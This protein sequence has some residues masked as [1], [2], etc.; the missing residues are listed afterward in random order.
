LA[1]FSIQP[2][3]EL[4]YPARCAGCGREGDWLC[5]GCLRL[6]APSGP[7]CCP[8]CG[9][10]LRS[11]ECAICRDRLRSLESVGAAYEYIGPARD[12]VRRFKYEGM[13]AAAG[14]MAERILART[15]LRGDVLT[16]VPMHPRRQRERGYNQ[17][18]A[19]ARA[20]GRA[21]GL[22]VACSL[23]R[24]RHTDAQARLG[25]HERWTNVRGAFAAA[26]AAPAGARVVLVDD[27]CTTCATLEECAATLKD[28]GAAHVSAVVFAR[29]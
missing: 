24:T 26:A 18:E 29:A 15:E 11:P 8:R 3:W 21:T 12:L 5:A 23:R 19:L 6:C 22:P 1:G 14:W 16:P 4:L 27:V 20:L 17:A 25:A 9:A 7:G 28:A 13:S 2:L 10:T